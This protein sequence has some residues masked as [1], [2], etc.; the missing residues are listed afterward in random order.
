[1]EIGALKNEEWQ[2]YLSDLA[3]VRG[4]SLIVTVDHIKTGIMWSDS[5]LDRFN[6]YAF[7]LNTFEDYDVELE[8]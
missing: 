1:M 7:E 3:S 2:K 5:M 6:F 8:Y 4:I